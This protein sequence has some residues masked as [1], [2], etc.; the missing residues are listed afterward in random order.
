M[1]KTR[2]F[3]SSTY[4]D[5]KHIRSDL[6]R[7]IRE[8]GYEPVL[9]EHGHIPYGKTEKLEE[10]CY[11]EIDSCYILV[12]IIG[13]RFGSESKEQEY[14]VSNLELIRAREKGKQVYI[15]IEKSVV[16]EYKTYQVNKDNTNISYCAVDDIRVYQFLDEVHRLSINNQIQSFESA[17]DI[18]V[19]LREQWS[20]LFQRLLSEIGRQ[21]EIDLVSDLKN[22]AQT[23]NQ[24]VDF[25]KNLESKG[26]NAVSDILLSNHPAFNEIKNKLDITFRIIF[27]NLNELDRL[28]ASRGYQSLYKADPTGCNSREGFYG[29]MSIDSEK[30]LYVSTSIFSEDT[31]KI[32][33]PSEWNSEWI[34]LETEIDDIF[35]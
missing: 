7:F 29:W 5:L 11:K 28:L 3:I 2:I 30:I 15:F 9:N 14:S 22:T 13:G 4:F 8:Q 21:K 18:Q 6:E 34:Y 24:L 17:K 10:Y 23:L 35:F 33:T 20:G 32:F 16:S 25:V 27:Q 19:Y 12:A 31:L 26:E 1:A